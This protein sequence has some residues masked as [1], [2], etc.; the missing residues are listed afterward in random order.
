M[1]LTLIKLVIEFD[2]IRE[3]ILASSAVLTFDDIFA[4]LL[5]HSSTATQS[6]RSEVPIDTLVMLSQSHPRGDSQSVHGGNC[7]RGQ[8][9]YCTYLIDRVTLETDVISYMVVRLALLM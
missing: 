6:R 1:I 7:G 5:H 4:W 9:P 8:R 2:T 3:Q